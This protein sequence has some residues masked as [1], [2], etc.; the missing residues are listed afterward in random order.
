[1]SKKKPKAYYFNMELCLSPDRHSGAI[2]LLLFITNKSLA[3]L[4]ILMD[5]SAVTL[6]RVYQREDFL[7]KADAKRLLQFWNIACFS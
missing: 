7:S 5:I 2:D 4:A 1:M 3:E 6:T